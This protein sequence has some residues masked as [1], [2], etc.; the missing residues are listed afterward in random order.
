M[1]TRQIWEKHEVSAVMYQRQQNSYLHHAVGTIGGCT[2]AGTTVKRE[3][4]DIKMKS[5]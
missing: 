1:N 4:A 5:R 2:S 3:K